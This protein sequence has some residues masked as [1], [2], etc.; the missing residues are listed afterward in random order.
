MT[1]GEGEATAQ[2]VPDPNVPRLLGLATVVGL[3]A[4]CAAIGF[5][6][7]EHWLQHVL[8]HAAPE[9]FGWSR[10]PGW[11]VLAVLLV[12]A[13]LVA[14]ALRLPGHGGHR[15]LQGFALDVG[16]GAIGSVV[17]A[18]LAS[19][20]FGA[21]LG[22]EAPLLAIGTAMAAVIYRGSNSTERDILMVAGAVSA[23]GYI[24]GNPLVTSIMVLELF[25][26]RGGVGGR[27]AVAQLLPV[28]VALGFGF[29]LQVGVAQ[30]DGFGESILAVPGLIE[31]PNV[32]LRD[33]LVSLPVAVAIAV[34][35]T[36][37]FRVAA[38]YERKARPRP[39][40]ALLVAAALIAAT[41]L[42]TRWLTD[43][44]VDV[45]LFSGQAAIPETLAIGSAG[46][47]LIIAAA[48]AVAY[49]I[50]LGAGFRGGAVFPAVFIGLAIGTATALVLDESSL[51]AFVA[52]GIAAGAAA[53][54]RLPFTSVLLAYALCAASGPAVISL[55][56]PAAALGLLVRA[57]IDAKLDGRSVAQVGVPNA[58]G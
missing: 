58:A 38:A 54:V 48:K 19:L 14:A 28:A 4:S 57:A 35:V 39:L 44:P 26:L 13:G 3:V 34:V 8:W 23:M 50:S 40:P 24:F 12:G 6:A 15:P 42:V 53:A 11:W 55:A 10:V 33:L 41:A 32:L 1:A 18:A 51:P 56:I 16:P 20:A 47:L 30:W 17:L 27:S 36:A 9:A 31:Y 2:A 5:V 25:V 52:A 45:V 29:L 43:E 21:V 7:V 22:P 37:A 49:G 46:T